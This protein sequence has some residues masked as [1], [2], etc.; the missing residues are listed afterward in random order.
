MTST[1]STG[2]SRKQALQLQFPQQNGHTFSN[3]SRVFPGYLIHLN[4]VSSQNCENKGNQQG[5]SRQH[6]EIIFTFHKENKTY[7][8]SMHS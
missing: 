8:F 4:I 5:S 2:N 6:H 3:S 1:I 7:Q